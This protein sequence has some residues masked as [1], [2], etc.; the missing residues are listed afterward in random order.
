[1]NALSAQA[2][3]A[4]GGFYSFHEI[5]SGKNIWRAA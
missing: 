4:E 1:V 5:I 3:S 2:M